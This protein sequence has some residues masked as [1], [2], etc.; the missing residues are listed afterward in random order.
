MKMA[1]HKAM[2][3]RMLHRTNNDELQNFLIQRLVFA[4]LGNGIWQLQCLQGEG[5]MECGD[6]QQDNKIKTVSK[7]LHILVIYL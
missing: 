3:E 1:S 6:F 2:L 4:F 5:I 7:G